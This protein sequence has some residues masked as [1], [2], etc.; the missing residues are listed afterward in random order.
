MVI[1]MTKEDV[2]SYCEI[3]LGVSDDEC[4]TKEDV[5]ACCNTLLG[6]DDNSN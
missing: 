4:I 1:F 3:V 6:L 5:F 2:I